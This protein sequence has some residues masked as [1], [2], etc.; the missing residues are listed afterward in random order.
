MNQGRYIPAYEPLE[1]L[2]VSSPVDRIRFIR[3]SC[4][5]KK[6]LDLGAMDE[7]AF[8]SKRGSGCWLHE[9]IAAVASQVVGIDSS[10]LVPDGGLS[11]A[12]NAVI[13]KGSISN[14]GEWFEGNDFRPEIVVAGELIEHLENP[15]AFL[16]EIKSIDALQEKTMILTTPNA[17]AAHNCLIS[18]LNRES[19]HHDHLAI[20]SFKTLSTLCARAGFQG[21]VIQPYFSRFTE[22]KLRNRGARRAI[23]AGGELAINGVERLFPLT[24]FGF[25]VT[26]TI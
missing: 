10:P 7:T 24:S 2:K 5:G 15:L 9:E 3:T 11:T 20:F 18:L 12:P 6:V 16:R 13:F 1:R 26:L 25:V 23:V 8:Q 21:W 17:T 4:R 14:L 19:T 22:M